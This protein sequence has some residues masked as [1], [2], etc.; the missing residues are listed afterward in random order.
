ME[1]WSKLLTTF[2]TQPSESKIN[3]DV[4]NINL[5]GLST[6]ESVIQLRMFTVYCLL[7]NVFFDRE[8]LLVYRRNKN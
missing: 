4:P 3:D 6:I 5:D 1:D 2:K 8:P 7:I